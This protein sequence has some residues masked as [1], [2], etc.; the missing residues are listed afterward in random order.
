MKRAA[1]LLLAWLPA[2]AQEPP[3]FAAAM[4]GIEARV[5]GTLGAAG[6]HLETGRLAGWRAKERFPLIEL[7]QLPVA[8]HAF[9]QMEL[10][11][12]PF[13]MM[14]RIEP[15]DFGPGH[16]PLRERHPQ[17]GVVT[18]GQLLEAAVRDNDA[19]ASDKLL[20]LGGGPAAVQKRMARWFGDGL[21]ID[22]SFADLAVAIRYAA[23]PARFLLDERDSATPEAF[24]LLMSSIEEGKLLHPSSHERLRQW[25]RATPHGAARLPADMKD[26]VRYRKSGSNAYWDGKNIWMSVAAVADLPGGR[27]RLALAVFLKGSERDLTQRETALADAAGELYRWF[28]SLPEK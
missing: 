19:S 17:G 28:A 15:G 22:R 6:L 27:G 8:L 11:E 14:L 12:M 7:A 13:H 24:A 16:S 9:A 18:V 23:S 4:R 10:G 20:A 21:R 3:A 5:E 1:I 26:A 2:S 25:M